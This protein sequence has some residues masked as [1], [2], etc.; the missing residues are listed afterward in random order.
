MQFSLKR[1]RLATK[2]EIS[3]SKIPKYAFKIKQFAFAIVQIVQKT[4][5]QNIRRNIINKNSIFGTNVFQRRDLLTI[6]IS[7]VKKQIFYTKIR[8]LVTTNEKSRE[9]NRFTL[10]QRNVTLCCLM[11]FKK[12]IPQYVLKS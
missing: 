8:A 11:V 5:N 12:L 2:I 3:F 6:V 10:V 9:Q 7:Y 4:K 1:V